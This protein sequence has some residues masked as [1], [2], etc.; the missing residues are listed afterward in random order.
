MID[1]YVYGDINKALP[2]L[3][4]DVL[5]A[6]EAPSRAGRTRELRHVGI[7]LT[8]PLAREILVPGR[9]VNLA[10]Q[11]A[12]TAW[13]LAG[14]NDIE[15]LSHY[16]PRA[17]D[18]SDDGK[19]WGSGYGPRLRAWHGTDQL[20]YIVDLLRKDPDT[21]QAVAVLWDPDVDTEPGPRKDRAC[22]N[23]LNFSAR[24][25]VLDLHVAVRSNDLMW[26]F[27]GIN[28][29]EWSVLLEVVAGLTGLTAGSLHFS[30]T[31]LH[32]YERHWDRAAAIVEE[33]A[34]TERVTAGPSP[35]YDPPGRTMESFDEV[36]KQ[37]FQLEYDIR[38]GSPL[39]EGYIDSFP[40]P[41][42]RSWLRVLDWWWNG[43]RWTGLIPVQGTALA[44]AA[45]MN[46]QPVWHQYS[47]EV[48]GVE[49]RDGLG[50]PLRTNRSH[51]GKKDGSSDLDLPQPPISPFLAYAIKTH[52]EKHAAYGDSWKRRGEMLGIM[53]NIARKID[54]LGGSATADETSADTAMDLMIYLAKYQIWLADNA[55]D[56]PRSYQGSDTPDEANKLLV[57]V[58]EEFNPLHSRIDAALTEEFLRDSFDRLEQQVLTNH[59]TRYERVGIMLRHAYKL[60][61]YLWEAEREP[62]DAVLKET[63][64]NEYRGAD[65]D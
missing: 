57:K 2:Q 18:F 53:A 52:N 34:K 26:G 31:S 16:M 37:W 24:G 10:A 49:V 32:L 36:L 12:E 63:F 38:T 40:E 44:V 3:L 55:G 22:N 42:L 23:W 43:N 58:E 50:E 20:A 28:A 62:Y 30:T 41:M 39:V 64:G 9:R 13:V 5:A 1:N 46:L 60:A 56:K 25:G 29:F 8:D 61:R 14:R 6:P 33:A 21:R 15:W 48:G 19:T 59:E 45:T 65:H 7:T 51:P 27:S 47:E 35:R 11:I 4:H 17:R 54:R